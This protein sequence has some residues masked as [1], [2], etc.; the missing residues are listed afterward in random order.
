MIDWN[1]ISPERFEQLCS[2][3]IES[4]GFYNI[5]RMG[6]SGDRGRDII[7]QKE[8]HLLF[9]SREIQ[10]WIIQCKRYTTTNLTI[11]NISSELNKVRIHN[12]N[13][14]LVILS[15]TLNP[16]VHD[17]LEGVKTQYLFK[18]LIFD[19]GW[20]EKQLNRQPS[21]YKRYFENDE[22]RESYHDTYK[23]FW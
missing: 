4:E 14:Y 16:N 2:D 6:G 22:K 12:P 10:N 13:Y 1:K 17:W 23:G 15:N 9:G 11:D 3:I 21:L 20:L 7:A 8:S 5:H 18:I 19:I